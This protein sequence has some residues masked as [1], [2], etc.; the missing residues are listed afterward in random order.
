MRPR[1]TISAKCP[2]CGQRIALPNTKGLKV[3]ALICPCGWVRIELYR[4]PL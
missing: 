3:I 1:V 4:E 2:D